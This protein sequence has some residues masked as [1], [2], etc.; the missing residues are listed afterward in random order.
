[1]D[2]EQSVQE[3]LCTYSIKYP[4]LQKRIR[5]EL[6]IRAIQVT[7][8]NFFFWDIEQGLVAMEICCEGGSHRGAK[9]F[10]R[11]QF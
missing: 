5:T 3:G 7:A 1:M 10:P 2:Q 9:H 6:G 4:H 8:L 11:E